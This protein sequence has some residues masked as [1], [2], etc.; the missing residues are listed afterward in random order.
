MWQCYLGDLSVYE[1]KFDDTKTTWLGTMKNWSSF[2]CGELCSRKD[3]ENEGIP[4]KWILP[5]ELPW[6]IVWISKLKTAKYYRNLPLMGLQL[7]TKC[8]IENYKTWPPCLRTF[9]H[10]WSLLMPTP[11]VCPLIYFY[12]PRSGMVKWYFCLL[13]ARR[14]RL[15]ILE[16]I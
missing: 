16:V 5:C 1:W 4:P 10:L 3:I 12:Q 8:N 9:L 6:G 7:Q 15:S 13:L 11:Q 2:T 14:G